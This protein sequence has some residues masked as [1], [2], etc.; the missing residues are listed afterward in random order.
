[1]SIKT[2]TLI[3]NS[4]NRNCYKKNSKTEQIIG[5]TFEK[6]KI[7]LES[8]FEPWMTWKNRGRY[9]GE[10]NY[11]WDIDHIIPTCSAKNEEDITRLNH[12]T[13]LQP[14]CG[15]INRNIK[16]DKF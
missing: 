11:G 8:K 10:L 14:L 4:F 7:H 6:F 2:R 12:F 15:Y 9:N 5:C 13:N 3:G 1:M 16:K